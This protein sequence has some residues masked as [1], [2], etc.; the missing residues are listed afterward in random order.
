MESL[1]LKVKTL[2]SPDAAVKAK[3][4]FDARKVG[5]IQMS[6]DTAIARLLQHMNDKDHETVT[7]LHEI[8]YHIA[9]YGVYFTMFEHHI[10]LINVT[11]SPK[12]VCMETKQR[13][14]TL[15]LVYWTN[16]FTII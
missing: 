14:R 1:L 4:D 13:T 8:V 6:S 3:E 2:S 12:M 5:V 10:I 7:K 16:Y 15:L 11:V 9:L